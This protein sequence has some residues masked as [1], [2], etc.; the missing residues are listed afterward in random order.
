MAIRIPWAGILI[1]GDYLSP[2]EI[3]MISEGGSRELYEE[4]LHRLRPLIEASETVVPGHGAPQP[5]ED[6]LRIH[7]EDLDYLHALGREGADAPLPKSRRT[8]AQRAIHARNAR[9]G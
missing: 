4:T 2:V 3:P 1:A 8:A 9:I 6:A 7:Q 5:R